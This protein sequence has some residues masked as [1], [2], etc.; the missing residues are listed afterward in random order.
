MSNEQVYK[1]NEIP[2]YDFGDAAPPPEF[3]PDAQ[4]FRDP[5]VGRHLFA[6]RDYTIVAQHKFNDKGTAYYLTQLRP[7]LEVVGS[8]NQEAIGATIGDFLPVPTAGCPIG[9]TLANRWGQ[10]VRALGFTLLPGQMVPA[11]LRAAAAG[12]DPFAPL[13]GRQCYVTIVQQVDQDTKKPVLRDNGLPQ[14]QVKFF[15]Y[16]PVAAAGP[17]GGNGKAPAAP[18]PAAPLAAAAAPVHVAQQTFDL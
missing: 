4:G 16:E 10:F 1:P 8:S 14:L 13:R 2:G 17:T 7:R 12:P 6:V 15:G 11:E 9:P 3:N 18:G 5:P